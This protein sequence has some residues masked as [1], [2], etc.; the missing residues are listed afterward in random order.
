MKKLIIV[1]AILFAFTIGSCTKAFRCDCGGKSS[2]GLPTAYKPGTEGAARDTCEAA[3]C[4]FNE[5]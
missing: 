3:G 2:A 5:Y 4:T 1:S